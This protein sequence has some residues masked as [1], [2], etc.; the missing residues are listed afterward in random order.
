MADSSTK[1]KVQ[2][3]YSDPDLPQLIK[4]PVRPSSSY[5]SR[6]QAKEE[7]AFTPAVV[8]AMEE[9]LGLDVNMY[10]DFRWVIRDCLIALRDEGWACAVA[11]ADLEYVYMHTQEARSWH[12]IVE[13]HRK[14]AERLLHVEQELK[15][16]R[17]DPHYRV[18]HLVYLAILGEKDCRMITTPALVEEIMD[19]M[20]VNPQDEP[21]LIPRVKTTIEDAYFRMREIGMSNLTIDG[22]ID[23]ESLMVNLELDRVGFMKKI[24]P[25]GL[26]YCVETQT[27]L[28][29]V[30]STG[31]HDVF[32]SA[33]AV[34]THST[35][36]RQDVPL[37]FFE[38][39]VCA[40]CEAKTAD[41]RCQ[42]CV[43]SFC[44]N[45]FKTTHARG[46]RQKHCVG[47]PQR[48]FCAEFPECEASY[49]CFQTDEVLST[50]AVARMR[51]SPARQNFTLFGLRKAAYSKKLFANNLDRLMGIMQNHIE[52]A[53]PLTPWYIFYDSAGA[54]YWYNFQ[55]KKQIRADP[56]NLVE[57]PSDKPHNEDDDDDDF[58]IPD[59]AEEQLAMGLPGATSIKDTHAARFASQAACFDVPLPMH[60]KFASP[61]H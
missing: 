22:C 23:V 31:S 37:V 35:G 49:V 21:Y 58:D 2:R 32:S 12:P 24:S 40:E 8:A 13:A 11:G 29:D 53:Y 33:A 41:V 26:L 36:K 30:I 7:I 46:K 6:P 10:P 50:K 55:N 39:S 42:D 16:K 3:T 44:Y 15:M 20:D 43:E 60:V 4:L 45:C 59:T 56:N 27:A 17:L 18:K 28:A 19:L 1:P 38:Q 61:Q 51:R 14:L 47:L 54:P 57:P 25:T 48:T 9:K 5:E 34:E 52:R